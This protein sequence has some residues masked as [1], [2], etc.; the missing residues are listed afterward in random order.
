MGKGIVFSRVG[1][2]TSDIHMQK[3]VLGCFPHTIQNMYS[4]SFI[5]LQARAKTIRL[6][7]GKNGEKI[8]ETSN[9][10]RSSEM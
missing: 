10:A 7:V 5:D 9:Y 1:V 3:D 2:G 6:P 8:S 4:K